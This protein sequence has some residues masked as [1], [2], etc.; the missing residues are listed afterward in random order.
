[1]GEHKFKIGQK[2]RI[3][4]RMFSLSSR[5]EAPEA[6]V[7]RYEIVRL[8]PPNGFDPQYRLKGSTKGQER[9]VAESEIAA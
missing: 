2:V 6:S 3:L 7:E 5:S 8:L 4:P 1:M 9:I